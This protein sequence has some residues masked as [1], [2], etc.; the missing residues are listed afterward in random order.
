MEI[1]IFDNRLCKIQFIIPSVTPLFLP[2]LSISLNLT[3]YF[4]IFPPLWIYYIHSYEFFQAHT[5]LEKARHIRS[6]SMSKLY[7]KVS[8]HKYKLQYDLLSDLLWQLYLYYTDT[9]WM[10]VLHPFTTPYPP[11]GG[12]ECLPTPSKK[13]WFDDVHP[14]YHRNSLFA[15][16]HEF[17]VISQIVQAKMTFAGSWR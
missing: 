5:D 10:P 3:I 9:A 12:Q 6:S 8:T 13:S 11:I 4:S 14:L 2:S 1:H 16:W 17:L 7:D 15:M